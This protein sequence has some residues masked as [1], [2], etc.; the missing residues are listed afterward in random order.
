[1]DSNTNQPIQY[2]GFWIRWAAYFVDILISL[3]PI[4]ILASVIQFAFGN[5]SN[6][7]EVSEGFY[8]NIAELLM[9]CLYYVGMTYKWGATLGK[10]IFG[11]EVRSSKT[12]RLGFWQTVVREIPG[13]IVSYL[14][15]YIGFFMA[16]FTQKKQALHDMMADTVVVYKNPE[17]KPSVFKIV[18]TLIACIISI[19]ATVAI[20][21]TIAIFFD[22]SP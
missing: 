14:I 22:K 2:A 20:L 3:L 15:L 13:K 19:F 9:A 5:P 17:K 10:K 7:R 18:F 4:L 16:G 21:I 8:F 12:E 6:F 11:L 1:M